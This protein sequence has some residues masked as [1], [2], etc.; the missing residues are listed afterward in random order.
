MYAGNAPLA[1][2]KEITGHE[3]ADITTGRYTTL[4]P[5]QLMAAIEKLDFGIDLDQFDWP[6]KKGVKPGK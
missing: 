6:T 1:E 4:S 2:F 3:N 5:Q